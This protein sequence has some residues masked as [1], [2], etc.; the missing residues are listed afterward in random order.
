[1]GNTLPVNATHLFKALQY[2]LF[3][4]VEHCYALEPDQCLWLEVFGDVTVSGKTQV[5]VKF[6]ADNL[7]DS[8]TNF[9]NTLKN[10]LNEGF[11]HKKYQ[12][13]VLLTTQ[14]YGTQT[15]LKGWNEHTA[16]QKLSV[17][18]MIFDTS[19][20]KLKN[21]NSDGEAPILSKSQT[22][23]QYVMAAERRDD[24]IEILERMNITTSASTLEERIQNFKT[25]HLKTIRDTKYQ[26]LIDSLL[27]FMCGTELVAT[28]WKITHK[29]FSDKL[30]ELHKQYRK[31]SNTFPPLDE[32]AL[33]KSIKIEEVKLREFAQKICEIGGENRLPKAALHLLIAEQTISQLYDDGVLFK[34][35]VD[36][37]LSNYL[38]KHLDARELALL[39]CK[40]I[41]LQ[42]TRKELSM[43]FF[44][45]RHV[46]PVDQFCS[47]ENT[48]TEFRNGIYHMLAEQQP[49]DEQDEFHWR[50]WS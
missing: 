17:M 13:L 1:M 27:G 9:W 30:S 47:F 15:T 43:K 3:V 42:E 24:L 33:K 45:A 32:D 39:D 41:S 16:A 14:N 36:S 12:T 23:Q 31:H 10:W 48:R 35:D 25:T 5:E 22:L 18:Q 34:S 20:E 50:L 21:C 46:L 11:D 49:E 8:H 19:R 40:N 6:Y 38:V 28:G 44:L 26:D 37:Y 7:T 2:Q 29:A 4:A